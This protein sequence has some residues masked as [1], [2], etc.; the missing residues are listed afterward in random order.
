VF[1]TGVIMTGSGLWVSDGTAYTGMWVWC[2]RCACAFVVGVGLVMSP[3]VGV[4]C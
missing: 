4:W 2:W 3:M 1:I